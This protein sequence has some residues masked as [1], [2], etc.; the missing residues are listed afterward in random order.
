MN[1]KFNIET[2]KKLLSVY[3]ENVNFYLRENKM[4]KNQLKDIQVSLKINKE[5]LFKELNMQFKG[6]DIISTI[7]KENERLSKFIETLYKEKFDLENKYIQIKEK[8]DNL[9]T[10]KNN[11]YDI[12][13][14]EIFR[15]KNIIKEKENIIANI[16]KE[17]N[18]SFDQNNVKEIILDPNIAMV[19]IN[20]ELVES[21]ELLSKYTKLLQNEKL[22][23]DNLEKKILLLKKKII[24][25]KKRKKIKETMENIEM[26]DYIITSNSSSNNDSNL[27]HSL[28]SPIIEF[29]E[30]IKQ[31]K[32]LKTDIS[33]N[34]L[35]KLDFSKVILKYPPLKE[36]NIIECDKK[37]EKDKDDYIE[38]IEF[39]LKYLKNKCNNLKKKNRELKNN[40]DIIKNNYINLKNSIPITNS[41]KGTYEEKN[42]ILKINQI[43]NNY[44]K[45]NYNEN[46]SMEVNSSQ[47]EV[48]SM[49]ESSDFNY[50]IK[51]FNKA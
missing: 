3:A 45:N 2:A 23:N 25:L 28:D 6:S 38:K 30:K 34:N 13:S 9:I 32:Y 4:L 29:P 14:T 26:F 15:L 50:I 22:K 43:N 10:E 24:S 47:I 39:E 37:S 44:Q 8:L 5:L 36:I 18:N 40:N 7:K 12:Q 41:T 46:I 49:C 1:T 33:E 11:I 31:K 19:E 27:N 42:N 35:P 20:N 21:R 51:E 16:N 17:L 48:D